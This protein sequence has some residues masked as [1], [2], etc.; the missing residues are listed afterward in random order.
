MA[1]PIRGFPIRRC[2][3]RPDAISEFRVETNNYSAEFGRASGAVVNVSTKSGADRFRGSLWEYNRN[4]ALNAKGPFLPP[5]DALTGKQ[6]LPILI[7]NQFGATLSGPIRH[8]KLF[9]FVDYEGTRQIR[10]TYTTATVPTDAERQGTFLQAN[11]VA[12]PLRNPGDGC[13]VFQWGVGAAVGLD[14]SRE[15]GDRRF[16]RA[17]RPYP[18]LGQLRVDTPVRLDRQ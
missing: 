6:Q 12:M 10:A 4:T 13:G 9:Y 18:Y 11:G 3:S 5:T 14:T 2:L 15:A 1:H 7:R 17:K 16:A 8:N